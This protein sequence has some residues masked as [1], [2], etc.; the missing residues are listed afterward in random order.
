ML[1]FAATRNFFMDIVELAIRCFEN[2]E[3]IEA[4]TVVAEFHADNDS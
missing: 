2:W 1:A 3:D 4:D